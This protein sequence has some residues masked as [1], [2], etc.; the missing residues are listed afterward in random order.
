MAGYTTQQIAHH[1][2]GTLQGAGDVTI[3]ALNELERAAPG[4]LTFIG[5]QKHARLWP[6]SRA[7]AAL[8]S[9]G[10]ELETTGDDRPLVL[11]KNADLAMARL[12]ALYAEPPPRPAAG[13]HATAVV[14]RGAHVADDAAIGPHCH[15]GAGATI[16]PGCVLHGR[17]SVLAESQLGQQCELWPGVVVRER[18]SLGPRVICH[19]NVVIG[20]DGFGYRPADDGRGGHLAKL[21]Q[22]GRVHIAADVEIGAGTCIDRGKFAATEIGDG[23][24]ID[25]L[26]QI[27]H[28][29]RLGRHIVIAGA[30]G[31]AG[32]VDVGDWAVIG[33]FVCIRD[34]VTIGARAQLA[35]GAQVMDEVPAEASYAGSPARPMREALRE[36]AALR[37]LP[38]LVKQQ[39]RG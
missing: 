31:L 28:N 27:G 32:S 11:V 19:P 35:G 8:V 10:V 9:E 24:K 13:I 33:G 3:D 21:P 15:I 4:E 38:A 12:L 6:A 7:S 39:A 26:V 18:C 23:C 2:G 20:A 34:H 1:V 29:C 30:T 36:A 25:N 14:E 16:G 37:K 5:D 22:I 17:V